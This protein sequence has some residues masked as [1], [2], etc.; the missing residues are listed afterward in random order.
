MTEPGWLML[1]ALM[2]G[3]TT[4]IQCI[5]M[6]MLVKSSRRTNELLENPAPLVSGFLQNLANDPD[7]AK[8]FAGFIA[9][10]GQTGI[11]GIKTTMQEAG[12]KPPKIKSFGDMVGFLFQM[13]QIQAAIEKK[14]KAAIEGTAAEVV[15][16]GAEAW[17]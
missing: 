5:E 6:W 15:E 10:M 13:P 16:K 2:T 14:A 9:W 1:I 4:L 11:S 7:F 8:E 12:I 3:A 17:L